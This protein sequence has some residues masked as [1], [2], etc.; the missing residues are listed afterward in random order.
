LTF[1]MLSARRA[2]TLLSLEAQNGYYSYFEHGSMNRTSGA[3]TPHGIQLRKHLLP[4]THLPS[5][6]LSILYF[7][8]LYF[9][10]S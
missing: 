4:S 8:L 5:F 6:L 9:R 7:T 1:L 3:T 10:P 2:F